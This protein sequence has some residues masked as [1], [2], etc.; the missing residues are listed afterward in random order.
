MKPTLK[1]AAAAAVACALPVF[2][3]E[4]PLTPEENDYFES[5]IR[6]ALI[7][8]C[9]KCHSGDKDAKI[10]GGLQLDSKAGLLKGG[11]TGPGLV[12]GQP[13][14]SLIIKAMRYA[15]PNLQMPPKDKVPDSVLAD[16][17]NWVRMGA[18]DPRTGKAAAVLKSDDDVAK[19][20]K[21]WAFQ[22]VVKPEPPKPKA[23]LKTWIQNDIDLFVLTKLEE[24]GLFPSPLADKWTLVRRAY[25]DLLGM[26]P[27][28]KEAEEFVADGSKDAWPRLI[29]KLLASPHYGERWGRYWLDIARYADTR[30]QQNNNRMGE[31][32]LVHAFTY[33]DW[34]INALNDDMPYD[35]FLK[36]Q[37]AA[38]SLPGTE[39]RH[40]AALGFI[41]M[42]RA[43]NNKQEEIDDRIDVITRGTMSLSVYCARCHDHKFD[44]I[45][46]K[47]YYSL[48]GVFDS[49]AYSM[50][51]KPVI[52]TIE[53]TPAYRDYTAKK[54]KIEA[55]LEGYRRS[56]VASF[57]SEAKA[58]TMDYMLAAHYANLGNTNYMID[59]RAGQQRFEAL[60]KLQFEV[61]GPWKNFLD[62]RVKAKDPVFIPWG[63]YAKLV[64]VDKLS[65]KDF[66][67]RS[68]E[69][70]AKYMSK[71]GEPMKGLNPLVARTFATPVSNIRNVA[72]RYAK[73]F[74]DAEKSW[75]SAVVLD[76]KKKKDEDDPTLKKLSDPAQEQLRQ[77]FYG[78]FPQ[79]SPVNVPYS[80][81]S[82]FDNNRIG[83]GEQ[84]FALLA[85]QL[86]T[87]HPGAPLRA[88]AISDAGTPRN[89]KVAVK[90]DPR[91]LGPEVPRQ[92]L[93]VLNPSRKPFSKGSGR[94]E[95]A[96]EIASKN[97]PLT[98]RVLINRVWMNHFGG[99][100]VRTPTDFGVRADDPTHPEL[101]NYLSAW[102]VENGWS[103]KKLHKFVM[104]SATYMQSSDDRAKP[105]LTDPAN[106]Q[107]WKMNRRRLDFEGFRDS[108]LAVSGKLDPKF[109]G[110]PV[111]I[112]DE[113]LRRDQIAYERNDYR[114]TLY[115]YID[116]GNISSLY[117]TFDF[118]NPDATA[119]MRFSS[120]V[121]QQA[122][123]LMNSPFVGDLARSVVHRDDVKNKVDEE[124]RIE[125]LYQ[126]CFQRLPSALETKI[127]MKF[128]ED[129]SGMK[130][131]D[132][133]PIW[134][135]GYGQYNPRTGQVGFFKMPVYTNAPA[136]RGMNN[137]M[138]MAG[139]QNGH[140]EAGP[141]MPGV[142]LTR[143]G[144]TPG[145]VAVIRRFT[146]PQDGSLS[147]DG[148]LALPGGTKKAPAVGDGV[149][150]Y[151]KHSRT[152][153]IGTYALSATT[154]GMPTKVPKVD[155]RKGDTIDFIVDSGGR[156][157]AVGDAFTWA[158]V[159]ALAS[160]APAG[161]MA[162]PAA[163]NTFGG[164]A[165]PPGAPAAAAGAG[166]MGAQM[167]GG[168][169]A[170]TW[171]ASTQFA[172]PNASN[173]PL[174]TW[175]K[176]AQ[177]LLLANEMSFVD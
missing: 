105:M 77:V 8:H 165:M 119:G 177:M 153:Q 157:N 14:R 79:S 163:M 99:A 63:D 108:L 51:P 39:A 118:A 109:G 64:E 25:F 32:R 117:R 175:E 149:T 106:L 67:A 40:L 6:P 126:I 143:D 81:L 5:K 138:D 122:L 120:T 148:R 87:S 80:R 62:R 70:S 134:Q 90:G 26:P 127:G 84:R 140:Y 24:K 2:A 36:Y 88:M 85:D 176:Y 68:K 37:I 144:G 156:G 142:Q 150:G 54:T 73:L 125:M 82:G 97:N 172:S 48:Y 18:P 61:A 129:Q 155:V 141:R 55:D 49:S 31:N 38:D 33:R 174:D 113:P 96:E 112:L 69:L 66:A 11:T 58:K 103:L 75:V 41:T 164:A 166:M 28:A 15:D 42:N 132:A 44:P 86:D 124:Q 135:Y 104:T 102:V 89:A 29:D 91:N 152:G 137:N 131:G 123:Y 111:R 13:D 12:A 98:A 121:P 4:K 83:N 94:L 71:D 76:S 167:G 23:H 57:V 27:S 92:F 100:L 43:V 114:R 1:F 95:L 115:G 45:P 34:V 151:I 133:K 35:K 116:R 158:P 17:E 59:N 171:S 16:F 159:L 56:E 136:A 147:I 65:D 52:Q 19:A 170:G 46:T 47:D 110:P 3:Q 20:R 130:G 101:L 72:E 146:A 139:G 53:D 78:S 169:A 22:Q 50:G 168:Q 74:L 9:H 162:A 154:R 107:V 30:G 60:T 128:L 161:G 10:K 21:H 93:E 160:S 7:E 173:K 145:A